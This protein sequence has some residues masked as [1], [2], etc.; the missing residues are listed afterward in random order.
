MIAKQSPKGADP[1]WDEEKFNKLW[2]FGPQ[3]QEDFKKVYK[4]I[5]SVVFT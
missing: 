2:Y 5:F 4:D 3:K 1:L